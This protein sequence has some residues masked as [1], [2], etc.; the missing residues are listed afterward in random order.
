MTRSGRSIA[1]L[2]AVLPAGPYASA[3]QAAAWP[4]FQFGPLHAGTQPSETLLPPSNAGQLRP[5]WA[6][7]G[8]ASGHYGSSPVISGGAVYN[9]DMAGKARRSPTAGSS[10]SRARS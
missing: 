1:A 4:Q 5:A 7:T 2:L 9:G 8:A 3:A 10:G 6:L